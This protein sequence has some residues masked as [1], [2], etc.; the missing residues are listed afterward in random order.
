MSKVQLWGKA[1]IRS[2]VNSRAGKRS[3]RLIREAEPSCYV[4]PVGSSKSLAFS[5]CFGVLTSVMTLRPGMRAKCFALCVSSGME[6][7]SAHAAIQRSFA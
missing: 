1:G 4:P 7:R 3:L 2:G 6:W 5:G